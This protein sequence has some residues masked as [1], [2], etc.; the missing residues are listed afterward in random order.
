MASRAFSPPD[1]D[2]ILTP[3]TPGPAPVGLDHTGSPVF[4]SLWTLCGTPCVSLPVLEGP[5]GLPMGVQL[6][7]RRGD[8]GRLLRTA[9]ALVASMA[10]ADGDEA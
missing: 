10:G 7:G 8:D 2:A 6:V 1:S 9:R 4:C 5:D 3:A